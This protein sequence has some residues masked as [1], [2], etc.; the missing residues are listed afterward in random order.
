[1]NDDFEIDELA[2]AYLD[3]AVT[4]DERARVD[5]DPT[6]QA[7]VDELRRVRDALAASSVEPTSAHARD[8]AIANALA[9]S[10]VI[11]LRA[12]RARRRVRIASIAAAA[13]LVV[14]A[15]GLLLRSTSGDSS[16]KSAATAAGPMSPASSSEPSSNQSFSVI[17][18]GVPGAYSSREALVAAVQAKLGAAAPTAAAGAAD[19]NGTSK[20]AESSATSRCTATAPDNAASQLYTERATFQ[21]A[22]VQIDVYALADGSRRVVVTSVGSCTV[23]FTQAL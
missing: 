18:N 16:K 2:S 5:A 17:T 6:L 13:I 8:S 15:A 22:P 12:E 10:P 4:D 14:G 20:A 7:R 21:G 19:D 11:D 3:A 9:L 23:V 1:M